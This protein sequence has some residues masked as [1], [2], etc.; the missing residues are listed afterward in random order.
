MFIQT[1]YY[2]VVLGYKLQEILKSCVTSQKKE[3]YQLN[4]KMKTKNLLDFTQKPIETFETLVCSFHL[5]K[6]S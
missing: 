4:F 3:P 2:Q 5:R 1:L 6:F